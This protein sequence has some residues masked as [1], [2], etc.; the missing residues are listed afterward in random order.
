M[1]TIE[2]VRGALALATAAVLL[3]AARPANAQDVGIEVGSTP[4]AVTIE[5][6][7]GNPVDLGQWIGKKPV[8]FQ[9][10]AT[11]CPLCE[12]LEPKVAAAKQRFGEKVDVVFV[13]VAVNQT[14]RSIQR[15]LRDRPMPGPVLW[16]T[17]G[18]ATR[19]FKAPTTSYIVVLDAAGKV[20]Y[21]GVGDDQDV[22]TAVA[23]VVN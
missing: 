12:A 4:A 15:H 17:D 3:A 5:D 6:L 23:R 9:F 11:W 21:T 22:A 16:D 1:R 7:E 2:T 20:T 14:K 13:A 19:A 10:W 8:V 18:K